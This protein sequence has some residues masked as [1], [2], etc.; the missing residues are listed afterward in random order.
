MGLGGPL[1]VEAAALAA[2]SASSLPG[3]PLCPG[4]HRGVVGPVVR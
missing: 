2:E 1:V 3:I 4:S